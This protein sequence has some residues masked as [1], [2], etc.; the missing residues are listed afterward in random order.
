M[1]RSVLAFIA[2]A[3][4]TK[5]SLGVRE[6]ETQF[7]KRGEDV[8]MLQKKAGCQGHKIKRG[9]QLGEGVTG[10]VFGAT[11]YKKNNDQAFE[12]GEYALKIP[13][14]SGA[15]QAMKEEIQ[16]LNAIKAFTCE[17][18]LNIEDDQPCENKG[19]NEWK[20]TKNSYI[21]KKTSKTLY[22]WLYGNSRVDVRSKG[23]KGNPD[24]G[25]C[26]ME[27]AKT[28]AKALDCMHAGGSVEMLATAWP[29]PSARVDRGYIHGDL[30]LDN[31]YVTSKGSQTS[32]GKGCQ[33]EVVVADFSHA[34]KIGTLMER[35]E[36][37]KDKEY[38]QIPPDAY[39]GMDGV[40]TPRGA[41]KWLARAE[42]DWFAFHNVMAAL[43]LS[44]TQITTIVNTYM[45]Q[46]TVPQSA[47]D[48]FMQHVS[49]VQ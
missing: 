33:W 22:T 25:K 36:K 3:Q 8:E 2:A 12:K 13:V 6:E 41:T 37:P 32:Q 9:S 40:Y 35:R 26:K 28:L 7:G 18:L 44:E 19:F 16:I 29:L 43:Q 47:E 23:F 14:N 42:A 17:G 10:T 11:R 49:G 31:M 20:P 38:K 45:P 5:Q 21:M 34:E 48:A 46:S 39:L 24:L 15:V 1:L 4:L 27:F 30:H